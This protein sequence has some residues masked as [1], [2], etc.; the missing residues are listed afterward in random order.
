MASSRVSTVPKSS[1]R[2]SAKQIRVLI[3]AASPVMR[4]GLERLLESE[5]TIELLGPASA[6]EP[7][8]VLL[9]GTRESLKQL[10]STFQSPPAPIIFIAERTDARLIVEALDTGVRGILQAESSASE[11]CSAIQAVVVGLSVFSI[12][13]LQTLRESL[14]EPPQEP[15]FDPD[16]KNH[17]IEE[18]TSREHEVL[19]M[20]ME[21]LSNKEIALQLN[22][23]LHT[24]KFHISS[25]LA[26]LGASSRTEATTIGL[27]RG[28]ITI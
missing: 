24:V 6:I 8:V 1:L 27:R 2:S 4:L 21:G 14:R 26:K 23:S 20:M 10:S 16:Y 11:L 12:Q 18:L 17:F 7:H 28:L 5:A 22:V 3:L 19:E 25:I 15:H 13:V 9:C